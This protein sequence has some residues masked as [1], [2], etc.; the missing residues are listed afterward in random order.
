MYT[1]MH[2]YVLFLKC[3]EA[4]K[5]TSNQLINVLRTRYFEA[6]L[7]ALEVIFNN[8]Y[9]SSEQPEMKRQMWKYGRVLDSWFFNQLQTKNC[10][11][12]TAV[13]EHLYHS[14]IAARGNQ[15]ARNITIVKDL[16]KDQHILAKEYARIALTKN[17][18]D[19][20]EL[21]KK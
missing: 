3:M 19:G 1:G 14:I 12:F 5:V 9:G 2:S 17:R 20:V 6:E 18:G 16:S 13:L 10:A 4:F 7:N 15:D 8:L 21:T 11:M